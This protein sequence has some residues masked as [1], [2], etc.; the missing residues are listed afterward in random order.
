MLAKLKELVSTP[1]RVGAAAVCLAA[2]LMT[3]LAAK[4]IADISSGISAYF[5]PEN[6]RARLISSIDSEKDEELARARFAESEASKMA[7]ESR[8]LAARAEDLYAKSVQAAGWARDCALANRKGTLDPAVSCSVIQSEPASASVP[9]IPKAHAGDAGTGQTAE[10]I[11]GNLFD[12]GPEPKDDRTNAPFFLMYGHG[13]NESG[14]FLDNGSNAEGANERELIMA[15]GDTVMNHAKP[16]YVVGREPNT[17]KANISYA[18]RK[19]QKAGCSQGSCFLL[20]LHADV[21]TDAS[22]KGAVAYYNPYDPYSKGM[23]ESITAC[24]G[25]RAI[26]DESNRWGR[27]A[28]VRDVENVTGVLLETG[29]MSNPEDLAW[30][31]S[32]AGSKLAKCVAAFI[33]GSSK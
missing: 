28:V 3:A 20:S 10:D 7:K 19:A 32:G 31:K 1:K 30:L 14:K 17:L 29:M 26:P 18:Q 25:G 33:S 9:L 24:Y 11:V 12:E 16:T 8:E 21:S 15:I 13:K 23:A 27:L 2:L 5:S 22:K 6:V 4:T